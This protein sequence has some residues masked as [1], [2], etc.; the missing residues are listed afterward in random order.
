MA[1]RPGLNGRLDRVAKSV[2]KSCY[3]VI[4]N[5]YN[6]NDTSV[7]ADAIRKYGLSKKIQYPE[8]SI[9][10][11]TNAAIAIFRDGL[12]EEAL[13]LCQSSRVKD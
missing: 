1:H 12:Q 4:A 11:R 6:K 7:I 8:T 9:N 10:T 2:F 5:N 3:D 13:N